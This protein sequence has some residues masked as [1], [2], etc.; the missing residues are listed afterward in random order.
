M[1]NIFIAVI[2]L[3]V[4]AAMVLP[5]FRVDQPS[6]EQINLILRPDNAKLLSARRISYLPLLG[7]N[8]VDA[9]I[10]WPTDVNFENWYSHIFHEMGA[11]EIKIDKKL[12]TA[13]LRLREGQTVQVR[14]ELKNRIVFYYLVFK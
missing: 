7:R 10:A 3:I 13:V 1:K 2:I 6:Q 4:L 12:I 5:F 8:K 11:K 14:A 9:R